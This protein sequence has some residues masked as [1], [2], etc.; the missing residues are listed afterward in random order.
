MSLRDCTHC[1]L[2]NYDPDDAVSGLCD[3]CADLAVLGATC[4][5]CDNV[6]GSR[7]ADPCREDL[8]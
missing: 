8:R 7:N 3:D 4:S 6:P 5:E 2:R 1:G